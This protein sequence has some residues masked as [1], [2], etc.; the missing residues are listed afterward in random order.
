MSAPSVGARKL[1]LFHAP[2]PL[3]PLGGTIVPVHRPSKITGSS[4]GPWQYARVQT[5][6]ADLSS[7]AARRLRRPTLPTAEKNGRLRTMGRQAGS[8]GQEW[9]DVHVRPRHAIERVELQRRVLDE[10]W[11]VNLSM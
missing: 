2:K 8:C 6:V 10:R 9:D 4:P 5:E 3:L 1:N 7:Y 11:T